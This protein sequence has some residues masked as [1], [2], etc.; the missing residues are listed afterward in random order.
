MN[1]VSEAFE[2]IWM[3]LFSVV[4][5]VTLHAHMPLRWTTAFIPLAVVGTYFVAADPFHLTQL[6]ILIGMPVYVALWAA[7]KIE[8]PPRQ[9]AA[10]YFVSGICAG[11]TVTFKIVYAPLFVLFWL[12]AGSYAF[13]SR[14]HS[15]RVLLTHIAIPATGGV[16][17]VL[18]LV[19]LKFWI[20]GALWELYWTTF[21]YA[22]A[23]LAAAPAATPTRLL[24]AA[25]FFG[26]FFLPWS[27]FIAIAIADWWFS[28]RDLL[29][30]LLIAWLVGGIALI[31]IQ[32]FS[33]WA[34]HFLF[35]F[36]PAGILGVR[37]CISIPLRLQIRGQL[38]R[39]QCAVLVLIMLFA[40]SSSLA[41]PAAHKAIAHLVVFMVRKGGVDDFM[42]FVSSDYG[43]IDRSIRFL[44][45]ET[46]RPGR[47]Y[48]FG[49]PLFYLRSGRDPALPIIGWPWEY[50]LDS[51]WVHLPRQLKHAR[52]PYIYVDSDNY[53]MMEQRGGGVLEFLLNNYVPFSSDRKGKWY[54]IRPERLRD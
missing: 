43:E 7:A 27:I 49:N 16:V 42:R 33:W 41:V 3:M 32:T 12:I 50:F 15:V 10:W 22:P 53:R 6:E 34:Y 9:A 31:L 54:Q 2:L 40:V 24:E 51:Q 17:M 37:G 30:A 20:D 39:Q 5:I 46:A 14:A 28:E 35:L 44:S 48:V 26:S 8:S 25:L 4:L 19:V 38:N 47:I 13:R 1:S 23:A 29:V 21:V 45:A 52:P 18:G 36:T 11:I